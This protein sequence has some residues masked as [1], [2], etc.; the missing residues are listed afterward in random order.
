MRITDAMRFSIYNS[1]K[2]KPGKILNAVNGNN[3]NLH[4]LPPAEKQETL[5]H[6][7]AAPGLSGQIKTEQQNLPSPSSSMSYTSLLGV[8]HMNLKLLS[9]P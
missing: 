6:Q 2:R 8:G 5:V 1:L 4:S 9:L 7:H 3:G